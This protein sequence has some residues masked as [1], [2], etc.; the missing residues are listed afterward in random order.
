MPGDP[1]ECREHA[2]HCQEI[3]DAAQSPMVKARYEFLAHTWLRLAN[4]LCQAKA[5]LEHWGDPKLPNRAKPWGD[6][7]DK[8][9]G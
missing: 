4:D 6:S 2:K 7:P 1:E 9:T 3:A 8:K 5:L